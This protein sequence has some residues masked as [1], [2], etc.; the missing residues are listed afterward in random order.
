MEWQNKSWTGPLA[1]KV[2][3]WLLKDTATD[4]GNCLTMLQHWEA[5]I[6]S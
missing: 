6:F 2:V 3:R 5:K 4:Y 1:K